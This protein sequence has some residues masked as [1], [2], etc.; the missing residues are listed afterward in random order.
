[1]PC[2]PLLAVVDGMSAFIAQTIYIAPSDDALKTL[3]IKY[4]CWLS[5]SKKMVLFE[6]T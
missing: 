6:L 5:A 4:L 3:G 1:M 2:K